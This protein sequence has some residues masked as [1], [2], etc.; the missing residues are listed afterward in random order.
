M[1]L[2]TLGGRKMKISKRLLSLF[3]ALL[4]VLST[5]SAGLT[6]FAQEVSEKRAT[7]S[8]LEDDIQ[9]I[10]YDGLDDNYNA[11][12]EAMKKEY[13]YTASYTE[14]DRVVTVTDNDS[15]DILAA[16]KAFYDIVDNW[17]TYSTGTT[18]YTIATSVA[19]S[20]K[21]SMGSDWNDKMYQVI[22]KDLSGC[23][24]ASNGNSENNNLLTIKKTATGA[25][26]S[27][28]SVDEIPDSISDSSQFNY[29][30]KKGG[31]VF[32]ATYT[33]SSKSQNLEYTTSTAI[34]STVKSFYNL[35]CDG[36][37]DVD[38]DDL[39][40]ATYTD[41]TTN[42]QTTVDSLTALSL[43]DATIE[44]FFSDT[45]I[46]TAQAYLDGLVRYALSEF[47]EI[48]DE[49]KS[50]MDGKSEEDFTY[51]EL[52][53]IKKSIK[54]A[55]VLYNS[56][57]DTQKSAVAEEYEEL[58][59]YKNTCENA[60]LK[61]EW[62]D[63]NNTIEKI[64]KKLEL[65]I[66]SSISTTSVT[67]NSD[68]DILSTAQ[69][70]LNAVS[71]LYN[72]DEDE[73]NN[74]SSAMAKIKSDLKTVMGSDKYSSQNVDTVITMICGGEISD[75]NPN[76]AFIITPDYMH[77]YNN[78]A[79]IPE[80]IKYDLVTF[81]YN[82]DDKL[83]LASFGKETS[84]Q[85]DTVAYVVFNNFQN[86]I[87]DEA[88]N[89]DLADLS[90]SELGTLSANASSALENI[91]DYSDETIERLLGD[92]EG[93]ANTVIEKCNRRLVVIYDELV[94]ALYDEYANKEL[95]YD[96]KADFEKKCEE[97]EAV[98]DA[99]PEDLRGEELVLSRILVYNEL[100]KAME[101]FLTGYYYDDFFVV[102]EDNLSDYYT[103]DSE[104]NIELVTLTAL[105][106]TKVKKAIK[107][108]NK[109][110]DLLDSD[111]QNDEQVQKYMD[112]VARLNNRITELS[113]NPTF[114]KYDVEYPSDVTV[115]QVT[116]TIDMLE[117]LLGS[118][119]ITQLLDGQS[120]DEYVT[121]TIN[122]LLLGE[123]GNQLIKT[124]I[125]AVYPMLQDGLRGTSVLNSNALSLTRSGMLSGLYPDPNMFPDR[126]LI[127]SN[128]ASVGK[129][130]AEAGT[131][132]DN[133]DWSRVDWEIE[134]VD[135][136]CT[137]LG[138]ALAGAASI[139]KALLQNKDASV[140]VV[141][142]SLGSTTKICS[143]NAGYAKDILP[144]LELL[145]CEGLTDVDTFQD[146]DFDLPDMFKAII[147]PLF[148]R[149]DDVLSE[150]TVDFVL[151]L[152]PN[153]SYL[154]TY[155]LL[156]DGINDL[157][158]PLS[159][160]GLTLNSL[161]GTD[162]IDGDFIIDTV[163]GL[164]GDTGLTLPDLNWAEIAGIGEWTTLSS[165]RSGGQRNYIQANREDLLVYLT[166][167]IAQVVGENED[168]INSLVGDNS[169]L[170][171]IVSQITA[172]CSDDEKNFS[173]ALFTLLTPYVTAD[174]TL[175]LDWTKTVIDYSNGYTAED[176]D[177]LVS[178]LSSLLNTALPLLLDGSLNGLVEDNLYQASIANKLFS[179]IYGLLD[180]STVQTVMSLIKVTSAD[181]TVESIDISRDAV[182]KN[183]NKYGFKKVAS[184]IKDLDEDSSI[185]SAV[186]DNDTWGIENSEDFVNAISAILAPIDGVL[187]A[188]LAGSGMTVTV[189]DSFVINGAN[190]YNNSIKP[191]LDALGCDS[192]E[193]D[194]YNSAVQADNSKA[195]SIIIN[196]LLDLVSKVADDPINTVID[197][198]P[199]LA[200][201]IDNGGI[202][203]S[204]EQLLS[205]LNNILK[206]V[207]KLVN[208]DDVYNWI[209]SDILNEVAG[210]SLDWDN[211]QNEIVPLLNEKVLNSISINGTEYSFTLPD[212]DF[213][214]LA[215][216]ADNSGSGIETNKADTTVEL[217][218]Y[219][220]N[221]VQTNNDTIN[222]LV[223]S[224]A[225][226]STYNTL[227]P[228]LDK[229]FSLS[230]DEV[231]T[232]L[233]DL[234]KATDSSNHTADWS[235][236][237]SSY[238]S[239]SVKYPSSYSSND[240]SVL[241]DT[242]SNV[243]NTLVTTLLDSTL[244]DLVSDNVY[245]N[246]LMT[247]LASSIYS[248]FDNSTVVTV[249]GL[250]GA[251]V[252][253]DTIASDLKSRGYKNIA[254]AINK[255][256]S[257]ST[258]ST[259]SAWDWK[260]KDR[261]SFVNAL[262]AV[263]SP[264]DDV[265]G[266][267]LNSGTINIAGVI[268]VTGAN[269]YA[270]SIKPLLD[271]LGCTTVSESKYASDAKKNSDN[272]ILNIINPLLDKVETILADPL[273]GALDIIPSVANFVDK[274]GI[275]YAV[276]EL[277]Y[278]VTAIANPLLF[279]FTDDTDDLSLFELVFDLLDTGLTWNNLQNEIIPLLNDKVLKDIKIGSTKL[280]LTIP[281]INWSKLAGC[282][283]LSS[284]SITAN[285]NN[286]TVVVLKYLWKTVKTNKKAIK[287]LVKSLAGK[288]TYSTL[289]PYLDNL[290]AI[291]DDQFIATLT[292]LVKGLDSSAYSVDWSFLYDGYK[293]T[294]VTYPS[295][296][297][298]SDLNKVVDILS[299]AVTNLLTTV[300]DI[301]LTSVVND[302]L[303]TDS[304]IT[305]IASSIYSLLD[306]STVVTVLGILGADV[307]K[308]A[309]AKS[310]KS[311]YSSVSKS[312]SKAKSLSK[313][314]TSKWKWNV[315]D[316]KSFAKALTAVLRPIE[317]VLSVFLNSGTIDIAGAI[318]FT[319]ANGYAN[320][321]KPM[322]D[323]LGCTTVSTSKYAS[324]AKKNKDNLLLNIINPVLDLVDEVLADPVNGALDLVPSVANFIDKGGVQTAVEALLYPVTNLVNP[325]L[326][327]ILGNEDSSIFDFVLDLLGVDVKWDNIQNEIIPLLNSK[328]LKNIKIGSNKVSL[329]L[330]TIDWS[331][332]A[333]CGKLSKN[334]IKADHAKELMTILNYVFD[335]LG[336]N[337]STLFKL[338]GGKSSTVGKIINNVIN[339]GSDG[340]AK[341]VV[342][343]LLKMETVEDSDWT[344]KAISSIV[345][346][347]TENYGE[348]DF[349]QALSM[350]DELILSMLD[351]LAGIS[352]TSL[353]T[354]NLYT[355]SLVNTVAK[356]I[357]QNLE[358]V[359]IGIDLNTVLSVLDVDIS[360]SGV[361]SQISDYKS[362]S[363]TI[364]KSKKWADVDFDSIDWG[365]TKGSRTD[366]VNAIAAVLRPLY[367][368]LRAVLSGEDLVVLGSIEIKG[369]N[370]YNTAIVPLAE[371][372]S[373][374]TA[375]LT[376]VSQYSKQ[377]NSDALITNILNPLL[378]KVEELADAPVA[379]LCDALPN[380]AYFVYNGGLK[381][382]VDNLIAPVTNILE[383]IDPI[384][385]VNLDLSVLDNLDID[386]LVNSLLSS[387]EV[388]GT[389]LG[390]QI[391]DIDLATL[392]GRGTLVSYTSVRTYD[393][394]QM[395]CKRVDANGAAVYIS[396][397]R[398]L[399]ENIK[400]NLDS[401][402]NLLGALSLDQSVMDIINQVLTMLAT[403]D[404]DSVI[405][406]LMELLFGFGS[407]DG[408]VS[409]EEEV[410]E[411]FDPFNLGNYYWVYWVI[412]AVAVIA[413]GFFL[414]LI[415]KK[416]K[417]DE[418]EQ[419]LE[420]NE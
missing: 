171:A 27:Y 93:D 232:V 152:L 91:S 368:V 357:Y 81:Y 65:S 270:N 74:T 48:V 302:A 268:D 279:L 137:A 317:D 22:T 164:L 113:G 63:Y 115:E 99:I 125:L 345:T 144:L 282:G 187:T 3:L 390:I 13:V 191:L 255:A 2:N 382:A 356:A 112:I 329:S 126:A 58:T 305:S 19:D 80:E 221:V 103:E 362:A 128:Y 73:Y 306:D 189:A 151:D 147:D 31:N 176:I 414:F 411:R 101:D 14:N 333:G 309:I 166:Y 198:L 277:L 262:V 7:Y 34:P 179:T 43:D 53:E 229:V 373:I 77:S 398:Y 60:I 387:V 389:K 381:T 272:L 253:K 339:C 293:S 407:D 234:I 204:V 157:L 335:V 420:T 119:V 215:G 105:D 49:V 71:L 237:Y 172:T 250:L 160:F 380:L 90:V 409:A 239:T 158:S 336:N 138:A 395:T 178:T 287:S 135:D 25:L 154:L 311:D 214:K 301:S 416:K 193:S 243:I 67:D 313:A 5:I 118:D 256:S 133:V 120:L 124:V 57:T 331:K 359:D 419:Q 233:I 391:T 145:G 275:Q 47:L 184:I 102:S 76:G 296:V 355:N 195:L 146:S 169:L 307:S 342:N 259:S 418:E 201:Y 322:L 20:L 188:L 199:S 56:Y 346:T 318:S 230:A 72:I 291:S 11:L 170:T 161:L 417:D 343:I 269:G 165:L 353:L 35:F 29:Y 23:G 186:I 402:N 388:K 249:L 415:L 89:G 153:L 299:T 369:G 236:L 86:T 117:N 392:A 207:A 295:G 367:P 173:S 216:C 348:D 100:C 156:T 330:P 396:V 344:F 82:H 28:N 75:S 304:T 127:K 136:F 315:T 9:S 271:A 401:I 62:E 284:D 349:N 175:E 200:L 185:T 134:T 108:V 267:L 168:T 203:Y 104:G 97:I 155:D 254:K 379:T 41:L 70:V 206:A 405:E 325:L 341:I 190:G 323:A 240:I 377:A 17:G 218:H 129:V 375:K 210:I 226:E 300:L 265:L 394:K 363:K 257:F 371:A 192:M 140:K 314:D 64:S 248:L 235:F 46:S 24:S 412:F 397:I 410:A 61:Y 88:L 347:Y 241:V 36:K 246:D 383:E 276:E 231:I 280:S 217:L 404:V 50:A 177:E 338:V 286:E 123:S 274:G 378:D 294:A 18:N 148:N 222:Q 228:Y 247:T 223:E 209:T 1:S 92:A 39:D 51:E 15:N 224:L 261:K 85:S 350:T 290:F 408:I 406:M 260:I 111:S 107:N 114:N 122:D 327:V 59:N 308:D 266:L 352:L 258:V 106:I 212:I 42:G 245:T 130:I 66:V 310:L 167:Y 219:I 273:N 354:D 68:S 351:D 83:N 202:Q 361:A 109:A 183:L 30:V 298:S 385:S 10:A 340:F 332:L 403:E 181:G 197:I 263:I 174:S 319:G 244:N 110:Y 366:F 95:T 376:S 328:V 32:K 386:S 149:L 4:I 143:G 321:V 365:V 37:V 264:L 225:G 54:R 324:D 182:I 33:L 316:R 360:T 364:A 393:S 205:P 400:A 116:N 163:S 297:T 180:D 45:T 6:A 372:L 8:S 326:V 374:D 139:V 16:A 292:A 251:D 208:T 44:R 40:N 87:T 320:A 162:S 303:Y 384:Y 142:M 288:D 413:I 94:T 79:D 285:K 38:Y 213:G 96:D 196:S 312:I 242:L 194:E 281:N 289:S 69:L 132:W 121:G 278:P 150:G 252:S 283:T 84:E 52:S 370:G 159:G 21:N 141:G 55:E 238:T 12:A 334:S 358:S 26:V 399:L 337:K 131:N 78:V 211:L 220:W 98:Y 227:S